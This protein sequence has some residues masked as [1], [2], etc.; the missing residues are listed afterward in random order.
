MAR[1]PRPPLPLP[2]PARPRAGGADA[3]T[4]VGSYRVAQAREHAQHHVP[5]AARG[6]PRE[7]DLDAGA[8]D[9]ARAPD[10]GPPARARAPALHRGRLPAGGVRRDLRAAREDEISRPGCMSPDPLLTLV[11]DLVAR[12]S[13]TPEDAGCQALIAARLGALGFRCESRSE[14]HTSELQSRENLVC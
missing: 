7:H 9:D 13:V 12:R 1:R 2:R 3:R 14:E 11:S 5:A 8:R 10:P 4:L 6:R